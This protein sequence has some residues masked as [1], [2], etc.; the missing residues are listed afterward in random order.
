MRS[1]I[2]NDDLFYSFFGGTGIFILQK[3]KEWM[4]SAFTKNKYCH[5]PT[6]NHYTMLFIYI[7]IYM[8]VCVYMCMYVCTYIHMCIHERERE[9]GKQTFKEPL[10]SSI[11]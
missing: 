1:T 8:C 6:F 4:L 11:L 3:C 5:L 10:S 9:R 2:F 7:Y